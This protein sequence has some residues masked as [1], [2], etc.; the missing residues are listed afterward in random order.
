[1]SAVGCV[2]DCAHTIPDLVLRQATF[3]DIRCE[4]P[5]CRYLSARS[6]NLYTRLPRPLLPWHTAQLFV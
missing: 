3:C 1:M 4:R 5:A 6:C 2:A